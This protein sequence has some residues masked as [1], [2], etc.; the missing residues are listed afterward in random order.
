MNA[1]KYSVPLG[2]AGMFTQMASQ[3][4]DSNFQ[5]PQEVPFYGPG[6]VPFAYP[7]LALYLLA[8]FIKLTGKYLI[9]L[10]FLP[11]LLGLL[12]FVPLYY[13]TL[14]ISKSRIAAL[15]SMI[16]AATSLDIYIAHVWS[17]GIVRSTAFI[18]SLVSIYFFSRMT[19][20]T[21]KLNM[22]M[23]GV[24]FGLA[25]MTHLAYALF[26]FLWIWWHSI[27]SK[28]AITRIKNSLIASVIG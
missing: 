28:D 24:F 12:S 4:A 25:L 14:E 21:N 10:R 17:A 16:I 9:F 13:I 8:I 26:C 2:A 5:L 19:N 11:P 6:G 23:T 18:L 15:V 7:P 20:E 22:V 1:L 3:I 27:F